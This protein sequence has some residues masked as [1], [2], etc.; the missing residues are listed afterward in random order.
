MLRRKIKRKSI[1]TKL[2]IPIAC[3]L[4][5]ML[6][7]LNLGVFIT[8]NNQ[9]ENYFADESY[10]DGEVILTEIDNLEKA[11]YDSLSW[12]EESEELIEALEN[13]D[14]DK[15]GEI[16]RS[17]MDAFGFEY[18]VV[19]DKE[20]NVFVRAHDMEKFGDNIA[21]QINIQK[22]LNGERNV[23]IEKGKVVHLS[24]RAGGPLKNNSGEIIGAVSTGYVFGQTSTV[25]KLKS[26]LDKEVIIYEGTTSIVS[27]FENQQTS[28]ADANSSAT[29][30]T[31]ADNRLVGITL[32]NPEVI[33]NTYEDGN[34]YVSEA[35][36]LGIDYVAS[37]VPLIGADGTNVGVV[38]IGHTKNIVDV[39]IKNISSYISILLVV[40]ILVVLGLLIF[41][42]RR[43]AKPI[44]HLVERFK[45]LSEAGGDLTRKIQI[46]T[47]DEL[48]ILGDEVTKFIEK[49]RD[50]VCQVKN[51]SEGVACAAEELNNSTKQNQS[52]VEQVSTSIQ[53]IA[54]GSSEQA[55][56]VSDISYKI[57]S[58]AED[59]DKNSNKIENINGSVDEAR[60]LIKNGLE[61]VTNQS[62]KTEENL[63]A[64]KQ[65]TE[66]VGKLAQE[67]KEVSAI[68]T[69]ITKISQQT[70]LLALNA[71]IEAARAGEHGRGF[72]VV[73]NEVKTLAAGSSE[74]AKEIE[75]ILERINMNT[76]VA[77]EQINHADLIAKEQKNAVD[78]TDEIFKGMTKEIED[79]IDN[80]HAISLSFEEIGDNT[81][82]IAS[83]IQMISDASQ[84]NAAIAEE[85]SASS[86]EQN[87]SMTE[88]SQTSENLNQLSQKLRDIISKFK[89]D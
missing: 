40:S 81:N 82:N 65:V 28:E 19:T 88:I 34:I 22:A 52:A 46:K 56:N 68:L 51:S 41:M 33:K 38:F 37:Y 26:I 12:F 36:I 54:I 7:I 78:E 17:I 21:N 79:M 70:N 45:E 87:A 85:V 43:I 55:E 49:I 63:M 84:E 18:V 62:I 89:V 66:V 29:W 50:I 75:E 64:F 5:A 44:R 11:A 67:A 86:E 23:G 57:Q 73:A 72:S 31:D 71:S 27:T 69:T 39:L 13:G 10:K 2:I 4:A 74:A 9:L 60:K 25:D 20:G 53:S 61:A 3:V 6:V 80:I 30:T 14:R 42:V 48:E 24:I 8:V 76:E 77:I 1:S 35:N 47:G 59:M 16:G 58:I 15:A 83:K 32:N